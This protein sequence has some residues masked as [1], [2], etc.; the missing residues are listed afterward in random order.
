MNLIQSTILTSLPH[1]RK[2]T[3]SGW[4]SFNAPCC[5][6]N[7]ESQDKRKRGG[8]MTSADGTLSYHC[9]NCGYTASY[10]IGRKLSLKMKT[11]MGWLGIADDVIKKLAIEAM[12]HEEA[13]TKVEKKE[14]VNFKEKELPK[15]SFRLDHW[16][17]RYVDKDLTETQYEKIDKLLNYLKERGVSPEWYDFFYSPDQ[18]SDF[19]RR[20]IIPFY[21]RGKIVGYTGRMFDSTNKE[22][23]YWTETQ[24]GYV[25]NMDAQDWN[26]KFVLVTEGPF[27]AMVL[28]GVAIL[29]SDINK[30]QRE[31]INGLG[32]KVIVVPDRDKAGQK[33]IDQ[34]V[35]FGWSVSFPKWGEKVVDASDAVLKYGRLFT[36]QSI[37]KSTESTAL[38]IDLMRRKM[39][40]G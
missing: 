40:N 5:V 26:R 3:P 13:D 21:W 36:L 10:V 8:L 25:F 11:L 14:F 32:R 4:T 9:F 27:D 35:E 22:I 16:L 34:A 7:G 1:G 15:N 19:H 6:H 30:T 33:L 17:E 2:K 24:P 23:K 31:L 12:R 28:G 20:L 38:K 29:G 39:I 37:L 18:G